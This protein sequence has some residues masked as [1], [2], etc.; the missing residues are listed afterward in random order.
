MYLIAIESW[1]GFMHDHKGLETF[2]GVFSQSV[3]ILQPEGKP[4]KDIFERI[5]IW[6]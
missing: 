2:L 1:N 4:I 5:L 3:N 6:N